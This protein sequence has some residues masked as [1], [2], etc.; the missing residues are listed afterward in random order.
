MIINRLQ[1]NLKKIKKIVNNDQID[2]YRIYDRDI[3]EY[4]FKVDRYREYFIIYDC[5]NKSSDF[6]DIKKNNIKL[7]SD[8]IKSIFNIDGNK[9]I[10][11][12]RQQQK[13]QSQYNRLD[14]IDTY[15]EVQEFGAKFLINL[16]DYLDTGIF[17]DHRPL[18]KMLR[19]TAKDKSVLNL[20]SY[21][22][23][24]SIAAALGG[25]KTTISV[26]MSKTYTNWS[27][28]NFKNNNILLESNNLIN[29][30]VFDYLNNKQDKEQFDI[31][32]LDPP[33]FS[34][35]KKMDRTLDI[36]RDHI[37]LINLCA[38]RL[39]KDGI[40]YFSNNLRSFKLNSHLLDH[41]NIKDISEK[42]VPEDFR[43]KKIHSC[44]LIAK[45]NT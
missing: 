11:K 18:R 45:K 25:S 42:T 39:K 17:L 2:S 38:L 15:Y 20:F 44:F 29:K 19:E 34:N 30:N 7:L 4:P 35:S 5:R 27:I 3:P 36:Q 13:G 28:D 16:H 8:G 32:I 33:S 41:Y 9:I 21:T 31:I 14:R 26:D 6:A 40:I 37:E 43:D 1:K 12:S 10:F 22:S 23:T 24:L